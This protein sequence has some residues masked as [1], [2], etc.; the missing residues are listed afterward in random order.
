MGSVMEIWPSNAY[1]QHMPKG[2]IEQR[3]GQQW[4]ATGNYIKDA[5]KEGH[6]DRP[7]PFRKKPVNRPGA[8][9]N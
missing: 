9:D 6:W 1:A 2:S 8:D 3:I 7:E 5:V 4:K